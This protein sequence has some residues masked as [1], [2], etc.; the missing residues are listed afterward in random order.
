MDF[1]RLISGTPC[2]ISGETELL[3]C[4]MKRTG[5]QADLFPLLPRSRSFKKMGKTV[6]GSFEIRNSCGLH[7]RPASLFVQE[8][9]VYDAEI[10]VQ[11]ETTGDKADG[12]SLMGLLMLAAP[13]GT[14]LTITARG[15]DADR[16]LE[17]LGAL[18]MKGFDEE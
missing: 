15:A 7:A 5:M 16:A 1:I 14:R 10:S 8:A 17:S 18:I 13:C 12:K 4:I 3:Y 9:S 6:S 2:C 11:N